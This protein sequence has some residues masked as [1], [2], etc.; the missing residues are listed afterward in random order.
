[1]N[2]TGVFTEMS[3]KSKIFFAFFL[4]ACVSGLIGGYGIKQMKSI[5]AS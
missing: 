3:L 2:G 1:M 5:E 4:A